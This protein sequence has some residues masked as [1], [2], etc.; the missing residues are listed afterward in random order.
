MSNEAERDTLTEQM[1]KAFSLVD[2]SQHGAGS[3][4]DPIKVAH[5]P[6]RWFALLSEVGVSFQDVLDSVAFFTATHATIYTR[7]C[8]GDARATEM[9]VEAAGYRAGPAGDW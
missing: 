6:D 8:D 1:T 4:K 7:V 5:T 9:V 3:W 2:P